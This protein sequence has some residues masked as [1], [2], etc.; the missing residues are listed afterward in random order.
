M[1]QIPVVHLHHSGEHCREQS[2]E[3]QS[4]QKNVAA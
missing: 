1:C 4:E 2:K 3:Q